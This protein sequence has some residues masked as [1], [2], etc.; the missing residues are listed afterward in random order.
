MQ[1]SDRTHFVTKTCINIFVVNSANMTSVIQL[2][3]HY[4][5]KIKPKY[6]CEADSFQF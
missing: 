3:L 5:D 4:E 6:D 2:I 1:L